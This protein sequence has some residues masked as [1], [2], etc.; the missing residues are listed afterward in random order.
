M[1]LSPIG[2]WGPSGSTPGLISKTV[3]EMQ[4]LQSGATLIPGRFYLITDGPG[5]SQIIVQATG[6]DTISQ[7]MRMMYCPRDYAV[8]VD[9]DGNDWIGIWNSGKAVSAGQLAIWGGL[10][11]QNTTGSIGT[12]DDDTALNAT[13]WTLI[14]KTSFANNEYVLRSF[15]CIY[16]LLNN[17]VA[18]QWDGSGNVFG[19]DYLTDQTIFGFGSFSYTFLTNMIDISDW[20]YE[21]STFRFTNNTCYAIFNNSGGGAIYDNSNEGIIN[22]NVNVGDIRNNSN[23]GRIYNNTNSGS[24]EFNSNLGAIYSNSNTGSI[25][26]NTNMGGIYENSNG[27]RIDQN[28]NLGEIAQNTNTAEISGNSNL[29]SI[30]VNASPCS[31][32]STNSNEGSIFQNTNAGVI[33]ANFNAGTIDNNSNAGSITLNGN[34]WLIQ[35]NSNNGPIS[36]NMNNG[37]ISG[38]SNG[39]YIQFNRNVGHITNN[40]NT[41]FI[42]SNMNNGSI[43][44]I[45]SANSNI[46]FNYNNGQIVTTTTGAIADI[47]INK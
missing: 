10:V 23:K 37:S 12:A 40:S 28:S 45:G 17:W 20:N 9:G 42:E 5:T 27:G 35:G 3:A 47:I 16:D 43:G 13:D 24:I 1:P 21:T 44:S 7:G 33:S 39:S 19:V 29:G 4:A 2:F 15:V 18:R 8:E 31:I 25:R 14:Y 11:W 26:L 36:S 30:T 32:I 46:R 22:D 6:T 34:G 41:G 38:N